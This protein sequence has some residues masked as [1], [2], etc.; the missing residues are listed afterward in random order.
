MQ[1]WEQSATVPAPSVEETQPLP[2]EQ[3]SPPSQ[4][5]PWEQTTPPQIHPS[6]QTPSWNR[7]SL[8]SWEQP[9]TVSYTAACCSTTSTSTSA[10]QERPHSLPPPSEKPTVSN[11]YIQPG[12][13]TP[14]TPTPVPEYLHQY[15]VL[16][17]I[18]H[19]LQVSG[20]ST[21]SSW[22]FDP[23][24]GIPKQWILIGVGVLLLLIFVII[25]SVWW[26]S[27]DLLNPSQASL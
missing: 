18:Q 12:A 5:P 4:K 15:S 9:A 1:A 22:T 17:S 20:I 25:G 8:G 3:P 24:G 14:G 13:A 6:P 2:W 23:T 16:V 10:P 19:R 21:S 11:P 7:Q 26:F 27:Q